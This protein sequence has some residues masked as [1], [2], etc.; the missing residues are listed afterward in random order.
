M[1]L[2]EVQLRDDEQILRVI[3]R[4]R[5]ALRKALIIEPGDFSRRMDYMSG[6]SLWRARSREAAKAAWNTTWPKGTLICS[7]RTL[8]SFGLRFFETGKED[9]FTVRCDGCDLNPNQMVTP[10]CKRTDNQQC[11]LVLVPTATN[12]S[13]ITFIPLGLLDKLVQV[14]KLDEAPKI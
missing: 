14:F 11:A 9:H 2:Q 8:K 5:S 6:I 10:L 4:P 12:V 1:P 7:A 3:A 13:E